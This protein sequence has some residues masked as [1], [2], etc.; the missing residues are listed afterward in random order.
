MIEPKRNTNIADLDPNFKKKF[1]PWRAEVIKKYPKARIFE[2]TRTLERQ[3]WLFGIGRTHS[4]NK[5]PVTWKMNSMHLLGRAVDIVFVQDTGKI[6][7]NGPYNDLIV[8]AKRYG[9]RNLRPAETCH[10]EG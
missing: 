2:T 10:F 9:I 1:D 7:R 3:K 6:G 5:K 8:M 4:F